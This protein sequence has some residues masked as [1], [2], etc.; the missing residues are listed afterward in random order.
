MLFT[1]RNFFCNADSSDYTLAENSPCVGTGEN[2][3]NMGAYGVGCYQDVIEPPQI[4]IGDGLIGQPLLDYVVTNYKTSTTLGYNTARD[5]LYAVIDL[6]AGNQL[7]GV[8]SGYTITLDLTQD[9]STNAYEQGINCEHTF[10][11]SMGAGDEPQ[12][13]DM[14]H[15]FPC[16]SN[17]NSSRGNDPYAEILDEDTEKWYRND[18]I[19]YTI[20]T[21]FIEEYAEKYN[22]S[23][24][25]D[26]RFEPK[27]DHKGDAARAMFYFYA[28]YSE[29]ADDDFWEIQKETLLNWHYYDAVNTTET[30]RTWKI[31][32]Y[33]DGLP[34]PFLLDSTLARR[35]WFEG[36]GEPPSGITVNYQ[37]GWNLVG[38]PLEVEDA[39]Y[40][41]LFPESISGTLYA[42]DVAYVPES[43]LTAGEGYW[44]RFNNAGSTTITGTTINE[45]TISLSE[46]W[47][48]VSGISE[49]VSIYSISDP[50][51]IIVS[52]TLYGYDMAYVPSEELISG[53]GYWL[54][55]YEDGEITLTSGALAKAAP[56]DFSLKGK[57]N[58]LN[59]NGMDLYF[60]VEMSAR[61]RLSYGLPPKPPSGAFDVRF[62]GDTKIA[63]DKAEIEVMNPSQTLTISYDVV[64][65]AG[66]HM[67][68]VLTSD[69]DYIL[70]GS[71][72][73]TVPSAERFTLELKAVVP[74][75]FTL[76]QN[77]PNPFNPITTLRYDLPEDNF[78]MLT[79]YDM[80]GRTVVQLV[81]TTQE[82]GFKSVQWDATDSMGR[83][84]SAG[85]YL[86]Q[87]HA[88][89]FVQTRK[90]VLLK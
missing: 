81:N 45:L 36:D 6:K 26:E 35:I 60:G 65:D 24:P 71:G 50:D 76:H 16:K 78:V 11:Q 89:E 37:S 82:A 41:N 3:A 57:A 25:T 54:R 23:D 49:T 43:Y 18:T 10:P 31:A 83:P 44:L 28:M 42:Y 58:S 68:W 9:P 20:P 46:G 12:K 21:E 48:L 77:F 8:Y 59:V 90:M 27:E 7:T 17:V 79:V 19:L 33:Q 47:N 14:H 75:T 29:I 2:G 51:G 5:T 34:N 69:K 86:Y 73:I 56:R 64:L 22:P 13:S 62:S 74:A 55:A 84:V 80:L 63:M 32:E 87:I 72:E 66:E 40:S 85:V 38:L 1:H 61:E 67:N 30:T 39:S 15:L 53:K 4:I 70:E 88:G 52:G